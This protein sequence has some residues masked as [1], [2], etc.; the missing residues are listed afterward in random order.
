[1]IW[2]VKDKLCYITNVHNEEIVQ[3]QWHYKHVMF[4]RLSLE[5]TKRGSQKIFWDFAWGF[6]QG[7]SDYTTFFLPILNWPLKLN[8]PLISDV[9]D[10]HDKPSEVGIANFFSSPLIANP[11]I[12]FGVR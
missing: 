4:F 11:L 2:D 12:F 6:N 8:S 9:V 7:L 3:L 10:F 1:M 5:G